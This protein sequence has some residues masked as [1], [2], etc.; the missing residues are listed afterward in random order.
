MTIPEKYDKQITGILSGLI[1]PILIALIVFL[2]AKGD[3]SLHSWLRR[4]AE[5]DIVTH[6]ITLC[7]FPNVLLFLLFNYFDMLRASKG[8]LGI[9]IVWAAIVFGVKFLL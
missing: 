1:L 9:T 8:I 2:F 5:A 3:P 6:V 7:V 4:I